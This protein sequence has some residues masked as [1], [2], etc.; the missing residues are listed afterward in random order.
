MYDFKYN[1]ILEKYTYGQSLTYLFKIYIRP[2]QIW[3]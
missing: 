1:K 2:L 3:D